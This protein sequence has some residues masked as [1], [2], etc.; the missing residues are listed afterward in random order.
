MDPA[1][2]LIADDEAHI[3]NILKTKLES[4][5]YEVVVAQDG[6][7]ALSA[8]IEMRPDLVITDLQ[9]PEMTGIDLCLALRTNP[10]TA[11]IPTIMLTSRGDIL[12]DDQKSRMKIARLLDKPFSPKLLT[13]TVQAVLKENGIAQA[14]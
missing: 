12:A 3:R 1:R 14:A 2:V 5:G 11:H 6:R 8:A 13:A 9:M 10:A 7:E 4:A